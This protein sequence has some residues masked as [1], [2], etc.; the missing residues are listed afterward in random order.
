MWTNAELATQVRGLP[1]LRGRAARA[2]HHPSLPR[3]PSAAPAAKPLIPSMHPL[4]QLL[5]L[6]PQVAT[7]FV[8]AFAYI[9][10]T[11]PAELPRF[12]AP[13]AATSSNGP[14]DDEV[15]EGRAAPTE[16]W[17]LRHVWETTK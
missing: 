16:G 5:L 9:A 7:R 12:Y 11:R 17:E 1:A 6:P 10:A 14:G 13:A 2:Q 3:Q 8:D 4:P 15:R